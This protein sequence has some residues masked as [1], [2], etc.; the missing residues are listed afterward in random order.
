MKPAQR[1]SMAIAAGLAAVLAY[2]AYGSSRSPSGVQL[3]ATPRAS[4]AAGIAAP[5]LQTPTTDSPGS[6]DTADAH[7]EALAKQSP[8]SALRYLQRCYAQGTCALAAN[9]EGLHEHFA[10]VQAVLEQLKRLEGTASETELAAWARE[11]MQFPD[12]HVQAAALRL[13]AKLPPSA[14]TSQIV[15]AAL[16]ESYDAVLL[17]KAYPVLEKWQSLGLTAGYDDMFAALV[18]TGGWQAAQSVAENLGPFLNEGNVPR[19]QQ[20]AMQLPPGA[21]KDALTRVLRDY[22]LLRQGG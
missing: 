2:W 12:G 22:R 1:T 15:V 10:V 8:A 6:P 7:A 17:G 18:S 4:A 11:L 16:K 9:P 5:S 3:A 13:A 20:I 21:R 14:Q 19:F